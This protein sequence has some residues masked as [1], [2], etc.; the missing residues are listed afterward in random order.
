MGNNELLIPEENLPRFN[1]DTALVAKNAEEFIKEAYP[2]LLSSEKDISNALIEKNST[3]LLESIRFFKIGTSTVEETDSVFEYL[4][5]RIIKLLS[6]A[7]S[8]SVPVCFGIIGRNGRTSIV[9]GIDPVAE[10]AENA[11]SVKKI[12]QGLL[13]DIS[14]C[15]YSYKETGKTKFGMIGGT[16]SYSIDG[17]NQTFDY[18]SL[19]RALN[20]RNY[21][22][23]TMAKPVNTAKIQ[24]KIGALT[25]LKDSCLAISKRN[26]SLQQS[27]AKTE[28][29]TEG[30]TVSD[31]VSVSAYAGVRIGPVMAGGSVG[32]SHSVSNSISK[33]ISDTITDGKSLGLEIQNGFALDLAKR[34]ENAVT[35]L[36]RG[37]SSGFWQTAVSYSTDDDIA[38]KILRGCLYSEI[39]KPDPLTLPPRLIDFT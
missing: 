18:S 13:P 2:Y 34:A 31:S 26:I 6:V 20:G 25:E 9:L 10:T 16:P 11:E 19:V 8:M 12:I 17:K 3:D 22:L 33:T 36:Q 27:I 7:Y 4:N 37:L 30:K 23:L 28:G 29:A 5:S 35:R 14:I 24:N 21:C 38:M 15:G 1:D 32:Y 39:A